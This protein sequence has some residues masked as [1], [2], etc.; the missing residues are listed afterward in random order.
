MT[1][2]EQIEVYEYTKEANDSGGFIQTAPYRLLT[3]PTWATIK[4]A[5]GY[6]IEINRRKETE[7]VF[8]IT[9]NVRPGFS[10]KR[11]FFITT[12][13]GNLDIIN[14]YEDERKRTIKLTGVKIEGVTATGGGQIMTTYQEATYGTTSITLPIL[15][16]CEVLLVF[17]DGICKWVVNDTPTKPNKMKYIQETGAFQLMEGDIFG[18]DEL[19]TILY[20]SN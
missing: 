10:W 14:I 20:R 2:T 11:I 19:I 5:S 12:R 1:H 4:P 3:A 8:T 7:S 15:V 18:Q 9:V 6:D 13:F 16:G 17:R